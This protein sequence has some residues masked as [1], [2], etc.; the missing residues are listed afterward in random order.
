M[1]ER[2]KKEPEGVE[3]NTTVYGPT[4]FKCQPGVLVM[5]SPRA[6]G[7]PSSTRSQRHNPGI[8][9]TKRGLRDGSVNKLT[10]HCH[11]WGVASLII[12]PR[13]HLAPGFSFQTNITLYNPTSGLLFNPQTH[14]QVL[15]CSRN[16]TLEINNLPPLLCPKL[17]LVA[18]HF[19]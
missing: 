12:D 10:F 16:G 6:T 13:A 19:V 4:C 11:V 2:K 17:R 3:L 5:S 7:S 18:Q 8:I 14:P 1:E 15:I 9:C